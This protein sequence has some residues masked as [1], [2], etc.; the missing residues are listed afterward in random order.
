M[1]DDNYIT[2]GIKNG[3]EKAFGVMVDTYGG[4]IKAI[5][6]RHLSSFPDSCGECINDVLLCIWRNIESYDP[7]KNTLKNWIGAV[8]KYRAIDYKR[9]L[10][11]EL[12]TEPLDDNIMIA[13]EELGAE[14]KEEI[15]SLLSY[16]SAED[17]ELFYRHYIL[18]ERV[19]DIADGSGKSRDFFFNRLSRGR[20]KIRHCVGEVN[21]IEK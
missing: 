12:C 11:R 8:S 6:Y 10:Y 2:E 18:G 17:K 16:L 21:I 20:K 1:A 5:V 13:S 14:L 3:D 7:K 19:Q 9:R 15:E 4:L